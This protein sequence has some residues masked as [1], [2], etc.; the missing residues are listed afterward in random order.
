MRTLLFRKEY[1]FR[2]SGIALPRVSSKHV[3]SDPLL[4]TGTVFWY[5]LRCCPSQYGCVSLYACFLL[6][7]CCIPCFVTTFRTQYANAG[8][9]PLLNVIV[10]RLLQVHRICQYQ[11]QL[12]SLRPRLCC[13]CQNFSPSPV[14]ACV[15]WGRH[16]HEA[17]KLHTMQ[18]YITLSVRLW[19]GVVCCIVYCTYNT[20]IVLRLHDIPNCLIQRLTYVC[21]CVGCVCARARMR[22][23]KGLHLLLALGCH[24]TDLLLLDLRPWQ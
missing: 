16:L 11:L 19:F 18:G 20:F 3:T 23:Y 4:P 13:I 12:L 5:H 21:V 2:T 17:M 24:G 9:P 22:R 1:S 14:C 6:C 7:C 10:T 15:L 8:S